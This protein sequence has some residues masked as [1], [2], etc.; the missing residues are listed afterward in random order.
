MSVTTGEETKQKSTD[1]SKPLKNV[2]VFVEDFVSAMAVWDYDSGF[3]RSRSSG[4]MV[5]IKGLCRSLPHENSW[6][7]IC[8]WPS[9]KEEE[10]NDSS[11]LHLKT[12]PAVEKKQLLFQFQVFTVVIKNCA[13][14][15]ILFITYC[16]SL[17]FRCGVNVT[18][19]QLSAKN[20]CEKR[21]QFNCSH[22]STQDMEK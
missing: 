18:R 12:I 13:A 5:N 7:E 17:S 9:K 19:Q 22:Q 1:P 3:R 21:I 2:M 4:E 8:L 10:V 15:W 14:L 16:R 11:D 20:L 6:Q